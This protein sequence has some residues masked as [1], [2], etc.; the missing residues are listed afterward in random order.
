MNLRLPTSIQFSRLNL[1]LPLFLTPANK[2]WM[3]FFLYCITVI[4]YLTSNH[5]HLSSPQLLPLSWVDKVVPFLPNT[6]WI[7]LSEYAFFVVVYLSCNDIINLNKYFYSFLA[8]QLV[9]VLIFWMLPTT[10]PR[11]QFPLTSDLDA[12]TYGVFYLLRKMDTP[13]NC[14]PS[15]H[16]SSVYLSTFLF[17]DEQR[18]KF[19]FF[20]IW[21]TAISLSTLTT[22]QHYLVDVFSGFFMA[23]AIYWLFHKYITYVKGTA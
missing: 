17:L 6:V 1:S 19:L 13:A 8:L 22:K 3:G 14:C 15:L 10:Y 18:K 4:L 12:L 2:Y 11:D 7:Y 20:F 9:S 5:F 23:A 16:V 21:G